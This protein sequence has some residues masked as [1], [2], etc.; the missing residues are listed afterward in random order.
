MNK[1]AELVFEMWVV[2]NAKW[3][4]ILRAVLGGLSIL[5]IIAFLI[6]LIMAIWFNWW[7]KVTLATVGSWGIIYVVYKI[8]LIYIIEKFKS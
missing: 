4:D 1:F 7:W 2:K 5:L 8:A 6:S 3:F